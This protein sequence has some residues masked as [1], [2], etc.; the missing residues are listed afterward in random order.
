M[1]RQAWRTGMAT[2][3]RRGGRVEQGSGVTHR[4]GD[5]VVAVEPAGQRAERRP[6]GDEAAGRLEAE[7]PA[8]PC[9]HADRPAGIACMRHRNNARRNGGGG[10]ARSARCPRPIPRIAGR[11]IVFRLTAEI[12]CEFRRVGTGG[13]DQPCR[14]PAVESRKG[15]V[16]CTALASLR[17]PSPLIKPDVRISRIRLSDWL[18]PEA[19]GGGPR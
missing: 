17:F 11:A 9:G 6:G 2:D 19:H 13:Y 3:F 1:S 4:P 14:A 5:R 10:G 8:A 12:G 18:H 7:D 16:V 15:A